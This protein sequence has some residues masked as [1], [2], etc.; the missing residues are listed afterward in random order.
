VKARWCGQRRALLRLAYD[1]ANFDYPILRV[2]RLRAGAIISAFQFSP[3][4][5]LVERERAMAFSLQRPATPLGECLVRCRHL[6][7][8]E[9]RKNP[10][11]E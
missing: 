2:Y 8:D 5:S 11:L 9:R 4:Q 7:A 6:S 3:F 1:P 10:R